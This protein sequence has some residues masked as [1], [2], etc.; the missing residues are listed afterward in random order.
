M[1]SGCP[2][3]DALLDA[4][5]QVGCL[6]QSAMAASILNLYKYILQEYNRRQTK[7]FAQRR[8]CLHSNNDSG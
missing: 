5:L 1:D 7:I 4:C 6:Q 3:A 8:L 2:V